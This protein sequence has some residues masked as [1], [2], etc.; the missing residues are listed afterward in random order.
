[1]RITLKH[2]GPLLSNKD[3]RWYWDKYLAFALVVCIIKA[4][5]PLY[6]DGLSRETGTTAA[7][8]LG[9]SAILVLVAVSKSVVTLGALGFIALRG[10]FGGALQQKPLGYAI[11][12]VFGAAFLLGIRWAGKGSVPYEVHQPAVGELAIDVSVLMLVMGTLMALR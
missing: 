10:I 4:F 6:D 2:E 1:M 3:V 7:I 11:A 9:I 8:W 5:G 12:I